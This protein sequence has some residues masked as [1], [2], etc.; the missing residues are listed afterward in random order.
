MSQT[1]RAW[2]I[3][4]FLTTGS[5]AALVEDFGRLVGLGVTLHTLDGR[6]IRAVDGDPPWRIEAGADPEIAALIAGGDSIV[7]RGERSVLLIEIAGAAIGAVDARFTGVEEGRRGDVET[8]LRL[9]CET[10]AEFCEE[11]VLNRRRTS[12]LALLLRISSLLVTKRDLDDVLGVA[13]G[14]AMETFGADAGTIHLL[15]E[16]DASLALSAHAGVSEGFVETVATLPRDGVIDEPVLRGEII[17]LD[18]LSSESGL[19]HRERT[20]EEGLA[21]LVSVGL[22]FRTKAFGIMRLYS[23]TSRSVSGSDRDLVRAVAEQISAAVAGAKLV[24]AERRQREYQRALGLA[25]SIQRRML[26]RAAPEAEG[27]D[28][29]ARYVPSLELGGD[30]YDLI[31]LGGH[32]G[33]AVGDVV[34][35]GIPAALLMAAVRASLRAHASEVYDLDEV[36][37]RVNLGLTRDTHPNEFATLF[38][39]VIDPASLTLTYCNA[40]HDP[41]LVVRPSRSGSPEFLAL[42]AG[43]MVVGVD[44]EAAYER[45]SF[46][47]RRGDLLVAYTD[48]VTDTMTFENEKFGARRLRT[49]LA[50]LL[51]AS[52]DAT[53]EHAVGHLVW[54]LNRF[55]GLRAKIDDVTIVCV[56]VE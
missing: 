23:R 5:L 54:E 1:D 30:F 13:L 56:R 2:S 22:L 27:L 40:G 25:A 37:R 44:E 52:P 35:K 11:S 3:T 39:G 15:G 19:M 31:E 8:I 29:A 43:G 7:R 49:S 24:E 36:V 14:A 51:A 10:A 32:L 33:V 6:R 20:V 12:E 53:A 26:P 16:D 9:V 21:G 17:V 48:G 4:D 47:L 18:D 45:A 28:V 55:A 41:P 38:Y 42:T 50:E 34:G 46:Q